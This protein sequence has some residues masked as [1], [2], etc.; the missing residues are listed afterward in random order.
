MDFLSRIKHYEYVSFDIFDT[1]IK[2]RV[3]TPADIFSCMERHCVNQKSPI[4][5]EFRVKRQYAERVALKKKGSPCTLAEIYEEYHAMY[6][7]DTITYME[8][9][10]E[11][12]L[13]LCFPNRNIIT[14]FQ[15]CV[16]AGL[17]VLIISDMYLDSLFLSRMLE[18]CGVSGYEKLFV[19]CECGVSKMDG[20]MF[21]YVL[22]ELGVS[23][24]LLL[25]IGD[26]PVSDGLHARQY[27]IHTFI[28]PSGY[29]RFLSSCI[30]RR[31]NCQ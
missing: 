26:N 12:E 21:L 7:G 30:F 14:F 19:S 9:E 22:R 13:E 25:H 17:H 1:L 15:Q 6:G 11:V 3:R 27:G 10:R 29:V 5:K 8:I 23:P 4:E 20:T 28:L 2:R 16:R 24:E 31:L 18:K